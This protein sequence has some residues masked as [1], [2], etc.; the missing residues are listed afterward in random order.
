MNKRTVGG[1]YEETAALYLKE[2]GLTILATNFRCRSGEIDLIALDEQKRSQA[3][4]EKTIVFVEVKYR[5]N[6]RSGQP[7][8]AV[9][10]KKRKTICRVADYYRLTHGGLAGHNFRFDVISI[11]GEEI[12]WFQN[13]FPYTT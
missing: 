10:Y 12:T 2:R 6:G 4:H 5:S 13:A 9:D 11:L 7:W 8:E 3:D 1:R